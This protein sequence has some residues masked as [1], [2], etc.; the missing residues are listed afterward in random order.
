M[1]KKEKNMPHLYTEQD[2]D[3]QAIVDSEVFRLPNLL[4]LPLSLT[5]RPA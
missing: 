3:E 5:P 1:K 2:L 4:A